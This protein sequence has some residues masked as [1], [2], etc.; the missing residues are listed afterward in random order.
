LPEPSALDEPALLHH[1][2]VLVPAVA[3]LAAPLDP[4]AHYFL[5]ARLVDLH[6]PLDAHAGRDE[7][8]EQVDELLYLR[9][10]LL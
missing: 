4:P 10:D 6:E 5:E 7:L 2:R 1:L 3:V 8:E 9:L